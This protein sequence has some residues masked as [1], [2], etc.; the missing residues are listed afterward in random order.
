VRPE[1]YLRGLLPKLK[2]TDSLKERLMAGKYATPGPILMS[3]KAVPRDWPFL[4]GDQ[5]TYGD[6]E[7][8]ASPPPRWGQLDGWVEGRMDGDHSGLFAF[9]LF[10]LP[11]LLHVISYKIR[12]I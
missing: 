1:G 8:P 4:R 10:F 9:Y 7:I 12:W 3:V 2:A 11:R 5:M 6:P